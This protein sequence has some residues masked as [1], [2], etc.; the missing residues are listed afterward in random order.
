MERLCGHLKPDGLEARARQLKGLYRTIDQETARLKAQTGLKCPD[1]CGQCC[2]TPGV[3]TTELE[4]L[5]VALALDKLGQ[6]E[7]WYRL[8]EEKEFKG[9]CVFYTQTNGYGG[10]CC[11]VYPHRP[12]IC[13]LF[14]FAGNRDKRGQPR[15][16]GCSVFKKTQPDQA[17]AAYEGVV[18]GKVKAPMMADHVMRAAAVDPSLSRDQWPINTA[19][20]K[21]AERIWLN[22]KYHS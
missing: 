22:R 19:F 21:A 10:G 16:V 18:S 4:M 7:H 13:R 14:G 9:P 11:S 3:E 8:A 2:M 6:L 15:L 12:L 20:R 17:E 1:G 5:P